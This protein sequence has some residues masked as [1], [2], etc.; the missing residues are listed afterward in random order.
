MV[1][2]YDANGVVKSTPGGGGGG[3]A[4]TTAEYLVGAADATLSAERVVT[5]TATVAWDLATAAQAKANVPDASLTSAKL[6]AMTSAQLRGVLSD[7]SGTG[8]AYFQGGDLGTPS[9]GVGTN[10]SGTAAGLTAGTVTTNANLTGPVTSVGNAT[11]IADAELAALAGLV[12]AADK[13]PYFTG[14]GTAALADFSAAGRAL[15]DDASASAQRTTLGLVIG[16]DVQAQDAELA[17][18]A[19]LTSA[20]DK[21]IQFTGAGTASTYDLTGAGKALL[22]DADAAAQRTTLGLGTLATQSGT[23]SGTSSGMNTGDQALFNQ[24]IE[25]EGTPVTQRSNVNFAGAGVSV[26]DTGGKT[27]VTIPG[28]GGSPPTGTGFRHVVAGVEDAASKLVDTADINAAQVTL[29][30]MA[31]L[32]QDLFI[33]RVTASTGVPETATITAAARTVLD[34]ATVA[35]MVD[36]L[37]GAA[38]TGTGGLARATSPTLVTPLLGTPTSGVLTNCTG[39]PV[40]RDVTYISLEAS[41]TLTNMPSAVTLFA[42]NTQ[43]RYIPR[44]D[45]TPYTQVRMWLFKAGTAGSAGSKAILRYFTS[46]SATASDYLDIGTSE[47]SVVLTGTNAALITSWIDLAAGA[48]ADVFLNVITSG[49]DGV[50]DPIVGGIVLQFK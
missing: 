41:I 35:A 17:A 42:G 14:A 24:T 27:V 8:A 21:G 33:G 16:T 38:S 46:Q 10:L 19:G 7:E 11:T 36:T 37:G 30:K 32:A 50:V 9:A 31:D 3:G 47:V 4:P 22:D 13:L 26:A 12:S 43:G 34:D 5:D 49:G 18:I 25:D 40:R 44:L 45:L 2:V 1:K 20:A 6:A 28:G 29:A 15:V 39:Y 23:F 48:K